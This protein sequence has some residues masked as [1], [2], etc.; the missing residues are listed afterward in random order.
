MS[1]QSDGETMAEVREPPRH[2]W[3]ILKELGPGLIVAGSI[4]GS[5]E[6]IATTLTGAEAGFWLMWLIIIGCVI[7]VFAQLEI[8]RYT[9]TTGRT[10]LEGLDSLPG[11]RVAGTHWIIWVWLVMF[12]ATVGQYGGIVGS[13]GQS[14]TM[15]IPLTEQGRTFNEAADQKV[16]RQIATVTENGFAQGGAEANGEVSPA[17]LPPAGTDAAWWA[18]LLTLITAGILY[19]GR[20]SVIEKTV[21]LMVGAFTLLSILNLILLQRNPA[22][23][24][25]LSDLWQGLS[26]RLPPARE[27][28]QPVTTALATFGIIGMAAGE[29]LYYPYWCLEKGY[30]KHIGPPEA[31]P[32]WAERARGWVRV[33]RWDAWLSMLVYTFSTLVFYLLGAAVLARAGLRAEGMDLIRMLAA[34]YEPAFG[35]FGVSLFLFGAMAV[36]F[37]TFFVGTASLVLVFADALQLL[38]RR[39]NHPINRHK[40][41]RLLNVGLPAIAFLLFLF[42][43]KPKALILVAGMTNTLMLPILAFAALYYRYRCTEEWLRPGRWWDGF[44]WLSSL[45]LLVVGLWLAARLFGFV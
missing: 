17:P 15:T 6:L 16:R 40:V 12:V 13:I 38:S 8:G 31:S 7:K 20:Y 5:G 25:S 2:V 32:E 26:F 30:A 9:I 10:A 44:L 4:V 14:V 3:G 22:W 39:W 28:L 34:M 24:V 36:L 27:G 11:I 1:E 23:A 18:L 45:A 37:S 33:M 29:L 41:R 43:P 35:E 19:R 42:I 21:M